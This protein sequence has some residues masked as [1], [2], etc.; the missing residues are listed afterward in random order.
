MTYSN[1]REGIFKSRPNRFIAHVKID[2]EIEICHVKNTAWS[3]NASFINRTLRL[4]PILGI[5]QLL[6]KKYL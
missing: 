4:Q 2:G 5:E 6:V 3:A 1:I